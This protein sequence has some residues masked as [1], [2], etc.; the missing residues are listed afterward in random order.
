VHST[1]QPALLLPDFAPLNPG[2]WL[3]DAVGVG[4]HVALDETL[5]L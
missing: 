5:L 1:D 4:L 3:A 2:Y